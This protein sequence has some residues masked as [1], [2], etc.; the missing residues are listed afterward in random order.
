MKKLLI[1]MREIG[2]TFNQKDLGF[3]QKELKRELKK[4]IDIIFSN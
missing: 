1:E 3:Y 2:I 4:K